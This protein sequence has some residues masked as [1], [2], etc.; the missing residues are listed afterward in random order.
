[1][2]D[3]EKTKVIG[4]GAIVLNMRIVF[5]QFN[6]IRDAD[7]CAGEKLTINHDVWPILV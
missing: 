7:W 4:S 5:P 6:A 2:H 3:L 1:M